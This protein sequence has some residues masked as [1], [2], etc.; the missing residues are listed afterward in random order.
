MEK[1]K[2]FEQD[3]VIYLKEQFKDIGF[4]LKGGT[5][6]TVSDILVQ[7]KS[8]IQFYIEAKMATAQ[9][10]QFVLLPDFE[11]ERFKYSLKPKTEENEYSE[12]IRQ[13]MNDNFFDFCYVNG[14]GRNIELKKDVFYN[15]I[16]N[17]YAA[18]NVKF[19]IS[20]KNNYTIIPLNLLEDFFI[21]SAKYRIK[22]SGTA[23]PSRNNKSEIIKMLDELKEEKGC[24][25]EIEY[26]NYKTKTYVNISC[27]LKDKYIQAETHEYIF[28]KSGERYYLRRRSKTENANVIFSIK[29]RRKKLPNIEHLV[30][31]LDTIYKIDV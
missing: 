23:N 11:G 25:Y 13:Y 20:R 30:S 9:C 12:T 10:G 6:S 17:Y 19:I 22:R 4:T 24:A 21:V 8:G 15:W 14:R 1:W 7:T 26:G 29:L 27:D 2:K 16:K 3:S 28:R 18:K 31:Y 5:D